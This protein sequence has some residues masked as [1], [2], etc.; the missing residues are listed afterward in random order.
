VGRIRWAMIATPVV[1][2]DEHPTGVPGSRRQPSMPDVRDEQGDVA[3]PW[4]RSEGQ[5]CPS[6][7]R[8]SSAIL[9]AGWCL[10]RGVTAGDHPGRA[11]LDRAIPQVDVGGDGED[12]IGDS[13]IPRHAGHSEGYAGPPSM[14]QKRPRC[15]FSPGRLPPRGVGD[16]VA[17]L[18]QKR[19]D[20]LED[21]WMSD[22]TLY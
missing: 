14:C 12:G 20:D 19:F 15:S 13:V 18:T 6:H 3:R 2:L 21:A 22:S 11:R 16:D 8:L 10:S 7:S 5:R 1:A 17:V 4:P 9:W